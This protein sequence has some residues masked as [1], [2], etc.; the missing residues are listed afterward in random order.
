MYVA[1]QVHL[2]QRGLLLGAQRMC[3]PPDSLK[4]LPELDPDRQTPWGHPLEI[5]P[6]RHAM[7]AFAQPARE[8]LCQSFKLLLL[9][10]H[11]RQ[12]V[13]YR[14]R[15]P[16]PLRALRLLT[17][18]APASPPPPTT[19]GGSLSSSGMMAMCWASPSR[20]RHPGPEGRAE[21]RPA[22]SGSL[23][24]TPTACWAGTSR[25]RPAFHL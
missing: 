25:G 5:L 15:K 4:V 12:T 23:A 13:C 18:P 2:L 17:V 19:S 6:L 3:Q 21:S 16:D 10:K 8:G 7:G 20:R 9:Q 22:F 1:V 24:V 11:R 14:C